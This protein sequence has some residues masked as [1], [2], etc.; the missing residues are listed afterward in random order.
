MNVSTFDS[1][2]FQSIEEQDTEDRRDINSGKGLFR[3]M[4]KTGDTKTIWDKNNQ[5]EVDIA[6][7]T[8]EKLTKK[9]YKAFAVDEKTGEAK[10]RIDKFDPTLGK[11]ILVPQSAGG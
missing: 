4:D 3:V 5:D 10:G 9:G 6:R 2:I 8:F 1:K 7:E 11:M